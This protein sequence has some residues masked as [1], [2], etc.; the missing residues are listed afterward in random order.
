MHTWS[1]VYA[2]WY[3]RAGRP[4]D[5]LQSAVTLGEVR[6]GVYKGSAVEDSGVVHLVWSNP[7]FAHNIIIHYY[8]TTHYNKTHASAHTYYI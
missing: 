5:L 7:F 4:V 3:A 6:N 8:G 2:R 1:N